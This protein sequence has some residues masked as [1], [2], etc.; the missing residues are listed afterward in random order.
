MRIALISIMFSLYSMDAQATSLGVLV[1]KEHFE[2]ECIAEV[3]ARKN[4]LESCKFCSSYIIGFLDGAS[5]PAGCE[6]K[7]LTFFIKRFVSFSKKQNN[8][9]FGAVVKSFADSG[10]KVL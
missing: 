4:H 5:N 7:D 10:C 9:Y 2:K 1:S 6:I 8:D 3:E